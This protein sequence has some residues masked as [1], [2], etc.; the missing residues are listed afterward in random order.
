MERRRVNRVATGRTF[1]RYE[2]KP[3][4]RHERIVLVD[5]DWQ[6][7]INGPYHDGWWIAQCECGVV[8]RVKTQWL[9]QR[10]RCAS[11][12]EVCLARIP[13]QRPRS[14]RP[15]KDL[16]GMI[17]GR[18]TVETWQP[19]IG[20]VCRCQTCGGQETCRNSQ[21]VVRRGVVGCDGRCERERDVTV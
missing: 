2:F 12:C 1:T 15:P 14:G 3:G 16:A 17:I 10:C 19:G 6:D 8:M 21:M 18:L 20:W 13:W 5:H 9:R 4:Y 7:G 11:A